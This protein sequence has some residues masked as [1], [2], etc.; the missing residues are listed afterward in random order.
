[1]ARS[2]L[3]AD[4]SYQRQLLDE[5]RFNL[6][7][8]TERDHPIDKEKAEMN[9]CLTKAKIVG[10]QASLKALGAEVDAK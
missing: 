7:D 3:N 8:A 10:I 1:M 6:S 4:L 5:Y 9:L 2:Q